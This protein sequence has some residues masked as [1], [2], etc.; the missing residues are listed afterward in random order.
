MSLML[1]GT[2]RFFHV[3]SGYMLYP[4]S[5]YRDICCIRTRYIE[6]YV[7]SGLVI[8]RYMLYPDSL[9]RYICCIRTHYIEGQPVVAGVSEIVNVSAGN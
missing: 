8:S 6:I 9:Y 4:D 3:A 7:V 2:M 5:L 1:A